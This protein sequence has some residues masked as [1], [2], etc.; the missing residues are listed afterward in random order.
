M[1][2]AGTSLLAAATA[3]AAAAAAATA[4]TSMRMGDRMYHAPTYLPVHLSLLHMPQPPYGT[5]HST[6]SAVLLSMQQ[7][8]FY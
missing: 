6:T 1:R 4:D 5:L 8:P 7:S 3:T 2:A